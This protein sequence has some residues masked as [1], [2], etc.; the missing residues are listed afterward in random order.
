MLSMRPLGPGLWKLV[1]ALAEKAAEHWQHPDCGMWEVR[2]RPRHFLSSKRLCWIALDRALAMA[3]RDGL[4]GPLE[5]WERRREQIRE[6][7]MRNGFDADVGA[8]TGAF[9]EPDLDASALLLARHGMLPPSDPRVSRTVEV[10]CERLS[11]GNGLLYRY[12]AADGL[13]GR[14]GAFTPCSFWLV[15]CLARRGR[16]DEAHRMFEQIV[17]HASGLG[18][19][20]EEVDPESGELLGNFPQALTHLALIGA[21]VAISEAERGK[22]VVPG[23]AAAGGG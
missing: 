7:V 19:L 11:A 12:I 5:V 20:S 6:A 1:T 8:F 22:P 13:P 4:P 23:R 10:V 2:D 15:D 16:I 3:R 17:V 18:L 14:E 21:A 9:G